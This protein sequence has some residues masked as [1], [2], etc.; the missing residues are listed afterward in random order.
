MT[1]RFKLIMLFLITLTGFGLILS[2]T[3]QAAGKTR[4]LVAASRRAPETL[5]AWNDLNWASAQLLSESN[6]QLQYE[7]AWLPRYKAFRTQLDALVGDHKLYSLP[8]V[9]GELEKLKEY[10]EFLSPGRSSPS[11]SP[12]APRTH[13]S[14]IFQP[15]LITISPPTK[16]G[17]NGHCFC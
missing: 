2:L 7:Q 15:S 11:S 3:L 17:N 6:P 16:S 1:L 14:T 13:C 4:A 8:T 9:K 5:A 12:A 10:F